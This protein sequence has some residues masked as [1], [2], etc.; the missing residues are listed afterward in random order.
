MERLSGASG[1]SDAGADVLGVLRGSALP[2]A[3][4]KPGESHGRSWWSSEVQLA[5]SAALFCAHCAASIFLP[6]HGSI[7]CLG[8]GGC[9]AIAGLAASQR[10]SRSAG[11]MRARWMLVAAGLGLGLLTFA[12]TLYREC[13][14][15]VPSEIT[16]IQDVTLLLRGLPFLM[17]ISL[18]N[19]EHSRVYARLDWAYF[20]LASGL[21]WVALQFPFAMTGPGPAPVSSDV[22]LVLTAAANL[23]VASLVTVRCFGSS[24]EADLRFIRMIA[25]FLWANALVTGWINFYP[26]RRWQ[27]PPGSLVLTLGDLPVLGLLMAFYLFNE[28]GPSMAA[29]IEDTSIADIVGSLFVP[30]WILLLAMSVAPHNLVLGMAGMA[31]TFT[32]YGIR[33]VLMERHSFQVQQEL[34]KANR[35]IQ[36]EAL[37][38]ALTGIPNRRSFDWTLEREWKRA[39]RSKQPLALLMVDIDHFKSLNDEH[40]HLAGDGCLRDIARLL[41]GGIGREADFAARY[42]G[43]EFAV[44]LVDT[45][46]EGGRVVA[47]SLRR[48]VEQYRCA[49][50]HG[51]DLAF[52]VSIGVASEI[53]MQQESSVTL[54]AAADK[55][56]YRAKRSGRNRVEVHA[57]RSSPDE[58]LL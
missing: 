5:L 56:L 26:L 36:D 17:A 4:V 31:G 33:S 44:L 29:K 24:K 38:D 46:I 14:L 8:L 1:R 34:L 25:A 32:L 48:L 30:F 39:Q 35:S 58:G 10:A 19:R 22:A 3:A 53:P 6:H 37:S 21:A 43:E 55:A 52:T 15:R 57:W 45:G 9:Y 40:G 27:V 18:S 41:R 49:G 11:A 7:T 47:E 51:I 50:P 16:G 42:G 28:P 23:V 20:A 13:I 12:L 2:E 54:V